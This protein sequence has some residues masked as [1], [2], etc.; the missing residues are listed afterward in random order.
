[1]RQQTT[2]A[3]SNGLEDVWRRGRRLSASIALVVMAVAMAV[4]VSVSVD[5]LTVGGPGYARYF[6]H[7]KADVMGVNWVADTRTGSTVEFWVRMYDRHVP[8]QTV[9]QGDE[10]D[11]TYLPTAEQKAAGYYAPDDAY[12][13]NILNDRTRFSRGGESCECVTTAPDILSGN[14]G[15][16]CLRLANMTGWEHFAATWNSTTGKVVM[17]RMGN[18]VYEM[19]AGCSTHFTLLLSRGMALYFGQADSNTSTL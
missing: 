9:F 1:M 11:Y 4:S 8:Y 16:T 2:A 19:A 3:D 13:I 14:G 18:R 17:Y 15:Q 5:A 10:T 6:D 7:Q 12:Q